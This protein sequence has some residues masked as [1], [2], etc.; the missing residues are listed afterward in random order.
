MGSVWWE[1]G[2]A[3]KGARSLVSGGVMGLIGCRTLYVFGLSVYIC[4][5]VK[6][7]FIYSIHVL[8]LLFL[9]LMLFDISLS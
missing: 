2:C 4:L 8:L 5:R 7:I 3:N 9:L 1:K 6:F